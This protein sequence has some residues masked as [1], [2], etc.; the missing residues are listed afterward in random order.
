M[1]FIRRLPIKFPCCLVTFSS[2]VFA[3]RREVEH[4]GACLENSLLAKLPHTTQD[5]KM[6]RV[7]VL[8]YVC[9]LIWRYECVYVCVL[10]TRVCVSFLVSMRVLLSVCMCVYLYFSVCVC[11]TLVCVFDCMCVCV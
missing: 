10:C 1:E 2:S 3:S 6:G 7:R 9:V 5:L 4:G 11:V 8:V